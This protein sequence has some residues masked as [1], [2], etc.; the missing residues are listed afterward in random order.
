MMEIMNKLESLLVRGKENDVMP[1]GD[2]LSA[3]A[4]LPLTCFFFGFYIYVQPFTYMD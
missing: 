1:L 2:G 3:G 4:F